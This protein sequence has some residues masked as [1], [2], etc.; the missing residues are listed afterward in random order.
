[1][2]LDQTH[3]RKSIENFRELEA[4]KNTWRQEQV[5]GGWRKHNNDEL[6]NYCSSPNI[7]V[8]KNA[9]N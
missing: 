5:E 8:V 1:V 4:E 3:Q 2:K 6:Y 7:L 9:R